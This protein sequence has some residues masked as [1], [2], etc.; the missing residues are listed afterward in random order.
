MQ[1]WETNTWVLGGWTTDDHGPSMVILEVNDMVNKFLTTK[2]C[3]CV[4]V[5]DEATI[6]VEQSDGNWSYVHIV[7]SLLISGGICRL[8]L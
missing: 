2:K 7:V 5:D 8:P 4:F 6:N 3:C 1:R